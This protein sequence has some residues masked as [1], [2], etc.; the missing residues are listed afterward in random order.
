[1]LLLLLLLLLWLSDDKTVHVLTTTFPADF[2]LSGG[3]FYYSLSADRVVRVTTL[4][5]KGPKRSVGMSRRPSK[6][7][8]AVRLI[9]LRQ[10]N[11]AGRL[12]ALGIK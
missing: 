3:L 8:T 9:S 7:Q 11:I 6:C 12:V 4:L 2:L 5:F 1:M 10:G